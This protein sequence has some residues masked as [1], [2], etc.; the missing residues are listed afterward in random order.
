MNANL[1]NLSSTVGFCTY[2]KVCLK[3]L[4]T[5]S[6]PA[7]YHLPYS[8]T[9]REFPRKHHKSGADYPYNRAAPRRP[10][11]AC[12]LSRHHAVTPTRRHASRV[13]RGRA[14]TGVTR[15]G[16]PEGALINR[17]PF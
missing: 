4:V 13:T 2:V 17:L 1:M 5:L 7:T 12:V 14:Q 3:Q 9:I 11:R 16:R 6:N 15:V 10:A 8:H